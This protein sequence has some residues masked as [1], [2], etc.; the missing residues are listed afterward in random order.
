MQMQPQ[1]K[2]TSKTPDFAIDWVQP[3]MARS[4]FT[5]ATA[6]IQM[7]TC[8]KHTLDSIETFASPHQDSNVKFKKLH[9]ALKLLL[10]SK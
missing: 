9:Q 4:K 3:S 10:I 6:A 8:F 2:Q 5:Q 1:L 7:R